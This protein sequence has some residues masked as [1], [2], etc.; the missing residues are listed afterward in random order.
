[1]TPIVHKL[2]GNF[3][4]KQN[5]FCLT[6]RDTMIVAIG[7]S[8]TSFFAGF[9]IFSILGHMAHVLDKDVENVAASGE[10][11]ASKNVSNDSRELC[12]VLFKG[13]M[14]LSQQIENWFQ[15]K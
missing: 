10:Y 4:S 11:A 15:C 9:V 13:N 2:I 1:M 7:N 12:I 3:P 6:S 14:C 5:V 8:L